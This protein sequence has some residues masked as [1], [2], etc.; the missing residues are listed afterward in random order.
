MLSITDLQGRTFEVASHHAEH[1][2]K[3][4]CLIVCFQTKDGS[5]IEHTI[6]DGFHLWGPFGLCNDCD[7]KLMDEFKE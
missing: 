6:K 3:C 5:I 2:D 4:K 1:C 7:Q